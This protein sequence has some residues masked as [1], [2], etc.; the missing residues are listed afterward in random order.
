VAGNYLHPQ[1]CS[2]YATQIVH[3]HKEIMFGNNDLQVF[4]L[5]KIG[6]LNNSSA[7]VV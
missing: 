3:K 1:T 2:K 4:S 7:A 5:F 6:K